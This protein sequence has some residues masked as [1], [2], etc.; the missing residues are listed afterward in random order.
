MTCPAC[1][2]PLIR[3]VC[4]EC[5]PA[6]FVDS[7]FE[8]DV[9]P[10]HFVSPEHYGAWMRRQPIVIEATRPKVNGR[11]KA[12]VFRQYGHRCVHCASTE[13]L[14][15]GHIVPWKVGGNDQPGNG[16]PECGSCNQRQWPPL[17]RY[18]EQLRVAA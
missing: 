2:R 14:T 3:G 15:F 8:R 16:V 12:I 9:S 7:L 18:L 10:L 17:A 6:E 4:P 5:A 1:T 13:L 11:W